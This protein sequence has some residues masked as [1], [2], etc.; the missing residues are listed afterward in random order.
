MALSICLSCAV[1]FAASGDGPNFG[2]YTL[3]NGHVYKGDEEL[4]VEVYEIPGGL[5]KNGIYAWAVL[6][7]ETSESIGESDTG[8]WF[9]GEEEDRFIPLDS[10]SEYQGL[11]WNGEW[12]RFVLVRG[13][14]MRAD[15]FFD[16]Y[17][18]FEDAPEN[19]SN[20]STTKKAEFSGM[21]GEMAWTSDGMRFVFTRIDDTREE[22]GE[23]ANAP[24]WLRLSA[25]L[26]DSAAD[27]TIVLK[28][29]TDTQN[30]RFS[31]ISKDGE[32]IVI[33]EEYVKSPKDWADEEK[34]KTREITVPVPA[35]G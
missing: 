34:V 12:D 35:A 29:S 25:V 19:S 27:E 4:G 2:A 1:S 18:L 13:G 7:T 6:G 24:Y 14:G 28:E 20:F 22:T 26:Y 23:L 8:V 15:M 9:F 33:S 31:A 11:L 17:T 21:R 3:R 16:V 5:E 30:F 32:K 10:E